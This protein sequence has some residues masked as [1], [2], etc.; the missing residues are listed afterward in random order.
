MRELH[1]SRY[2]LFPGFS[3]NFSYYKTPRMMLPGAA[4]PRLQGQG[5][6]LLGLMKTRL[7]EDWALQ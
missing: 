1:D 6:A 5:V 7:R 2:K 4:L 3:S